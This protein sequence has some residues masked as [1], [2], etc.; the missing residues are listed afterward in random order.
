MK[1]CQLCNM[2]MPCLYGKGNNNYKCEICN[3]EYWWHWK[4]P[5]PNCCLLRD[6]DYRFRFTFHKNTCEI[7]KS[8]IFQFPQVK[9]FNT[10]AF[11]FWNTIIKLNCIPKG[12]TPQNIKAKLKTYIVF[13]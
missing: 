10:G 8:F 5:N 4:E 11:E 13:S 7:Q 3:L 9:G 1:T 6:E 12:I 2:G